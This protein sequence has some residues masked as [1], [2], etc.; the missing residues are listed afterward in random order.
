MGTHGSNLLRDSFMQCT[1]RKMSTLHHGGYRQCRSH[2]SPL[3]LLPLPACPPLN[4][5]RSSHAVWHERED[6]PPYLPPRCRGP[7]QR[8]LRPEGPVLQAER[9]GAEDQEAGECSAKSTPLL[10][11]CL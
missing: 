8:H 1:V 3:S 11:V 2:F 5:P 4:M 6:N 10:R 9:Q 7:V